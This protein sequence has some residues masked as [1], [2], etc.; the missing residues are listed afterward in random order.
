[1]ERKL[2]TIGI[3]LYFSYLLWKWVEI[4][5]HLCFVWIVNTFWV[6][7]NAHNFCGSRRFLV[8]STIPI[9][10]WSSCHSH[11][12]TTVPRFIFDSSRAL[13][14]FRPIYVWRLVACSW[15]QLVDCC[16][17]LVN[18]FISFILTNCTFYYLPLAHF[19]QCPIDLLYLFWRTCS[20]SCLL[21]FCFLPVCFV[22]F[23]IKR[24]LL[25]NW[26][27]LHQI[28]NWNS[29]RI[30]K[31]ER[32]SLCPEAKDT[33]KSRKRRRRTSQEES[34]KLNK[35]DQVLHRNTFS[36]FFS[37]LDFSVVLSQTG[38]HVLVNAT[39]HTSY[40]IRYKQMADA[41]REEEQ[42]QLLGE[43]GVRSGQAQGQ[44]LKLG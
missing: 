11:E 41:N 3:T 10:Y 39:S 23:L 27:E 40:K 36:L 5:F 38:S 28:W 9:K 20:F 1:M 25:W 44:N 16:M 42:I 8:W 33:M 31:S 43:E 34:S 29:T 37:L 13:F 14:M 24:S 30:R 35:E 17:W 12:P 32:S 19:N 6:W 2:P 26:I 4:E 18:I 7:I 21:E 22:F 15:T